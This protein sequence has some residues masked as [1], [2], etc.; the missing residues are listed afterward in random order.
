M[1]RIAYR[2]YLLFQLQTTVKHSQQDSYIG[3]YHGNFSYL[4]RIGQSV[5][6]LMVDARAERTRKQIVSSDVWSLIFDRVQLL[7]SEVQHLV[8]VSGVPIVYP[9]LS[10]AEGVLSSIGKA[11]EAANKGFNNFAKDL[12]AG[13]GKVFG[14]KT[15][16]NFHEATVNMKKALGKTGLMSKVLNHFGEPE[17]EDDLIDHWTNEN[18][19]EERS[20]I[21]SR[22][23]SISKENK[24]RVTFA[25]GDVHCGGF[26]RMY[27]KSGEEDHHL[28]YQVI[29]SAIGNVP[30]PKAVLQTVHSSCA[31]IVFNNETMEEMVDTFDKDVNGQVL[32]GKKLIGR[33]NYAIVNAVED[34]SLSFSLQVEAEDY[35]SPTAGYEK[36]VPI[37]Q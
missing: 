24:L 28:M 35:K 17:L 6:I 16:Q 2:F 9:R 31:K 7:P 22:F 18:H 27:A 19:K 5:A 12:G 21:I 36:K 15:Q 32:K 10:T 29:S 1:K 20:M 37:M 23:Q 14:E 13:L 33:R 26:G 30:P 4:R 25:A 11:K 8:V 34:G 3:S